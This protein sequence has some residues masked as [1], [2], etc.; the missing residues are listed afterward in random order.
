MKDFDETQAVNFI[1]SRLGNK[2]Y[3]ADEILNII[4]MIWDFYESNG[5]LEIDDDNDEDE[6]IEESLV[7]YVTKMINRD[8]DANVNVEDIP[9]I[10]AAELDYEESLYDED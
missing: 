7:E 5:M 10:V 8:K 4:D 2:K 3:P 6:D 9:A 1:N